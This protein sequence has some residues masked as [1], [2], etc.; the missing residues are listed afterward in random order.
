MKT[1]RTRNILGLLR[2]PFFIAYSVPI[3]LIHSN[4]IGTLLHTLNRV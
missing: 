3:T 1:G 4:D 2:F